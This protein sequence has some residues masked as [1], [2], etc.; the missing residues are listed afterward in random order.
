MSN[1]PNRLPKNTKTSKPRD[2]GTP[3]TGVEK[4]ALLNLL[5]AAVGWMAAK[6]NMR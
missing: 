4:L 2:P 5:G 3:L 6:G 1:K